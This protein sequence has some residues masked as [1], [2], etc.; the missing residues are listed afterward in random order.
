MNLPS[1]GSFLF[2]LIV[3]IFA[4][5]WVY[6]ATLL[7]ARAIARVKHERHDNGKE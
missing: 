3:S 2:W 1:G 6:I 5:I 4:L 7:V